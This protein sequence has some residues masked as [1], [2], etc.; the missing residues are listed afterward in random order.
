[1]ERLREFVL[2]EL[3]AKREP[4]VRLDCEHDD[5]G[6]MK[7]V[8]QYMQSIGVSVAIPWTREE[9]EFSF[10]PFEQK[11]RWEDSDD[12]YYDEIFNA[13]PEDKYKFLKV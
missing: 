7:R 2:T 3:V 10:K 4:V 9:I 1:M 12:N 6:Y 11:K 5:Y 13:K 8:A